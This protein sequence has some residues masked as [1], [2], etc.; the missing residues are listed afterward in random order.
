[1]WCARLAVLV[2]AA[3]RRDYM[4]DVR[5]LSRSYAGSSSG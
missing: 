2:S 4:R 5:G 1:M 3:L